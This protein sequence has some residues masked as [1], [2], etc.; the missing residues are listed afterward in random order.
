MAT[1]EIYVIMVENDDKLLE[2]I[3][4]LVDQISNLIYCLPLLLLHYP[5]NKIWNTSMLS[6]L[7]K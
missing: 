3:Q 1:E 5:R 2:K 7:C 6:L 4:K